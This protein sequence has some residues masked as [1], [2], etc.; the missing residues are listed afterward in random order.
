MELP[1]VLT[2][3]LKNKYVTAG[4]SLFLVLYAGMA[5]PQLPGF[6]A[7]LFDNAVFRMLILSLVV[8]MGGHNLQLS[9]MVAVAFTVTMNLLNEQ[10]IAEGFV[11][12]IRENMITENFSD[13]LSDMEDM[14]DDSM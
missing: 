14:D 4:T 6:V 11:D 7:G 9:V 8:F 2:N 3:A 13:D 12:G 10:K 1:K 5:R